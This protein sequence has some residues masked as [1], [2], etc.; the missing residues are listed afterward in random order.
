MQ[1][2]LELV[3]SYQGGELQRSAFVR[4]LVAGGVSLSAALAYAVALAPPA[5]ADAE[6]DVAKTCQQ[7]GEQSTACQRKVA[8]YCRERGFE[9][10]DFYNDFYGG[11]VACFYSINGDF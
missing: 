6:G 2:R 5:Q 3:Q 1:E 7:R 11:G 10:G 9:A 8:K 4:R